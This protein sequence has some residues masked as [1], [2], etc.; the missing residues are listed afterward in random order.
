[1][2]TAPRTR[3]LREEQIIIAVDR[4][5][6]HVARHWVWLL[7][8]IG[9]L[10]AGLPVL[11]PVLESSGHHRVAGVIYRSFS[12]IC[13]QTPDHTFHLFGYRLAYCERCMSI[14]G[15]LLLL[16]LIYGASKRSLRPAT[17][18][19]AGVLSL[20]IALD[21]LTQLV[22]LRQS[23]WEIRVITGTLFSIAIAW[24]VMPRLDAGFRDVTRTVEAQFA[25]L[26]VEGR[27]KPLT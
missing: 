9:A 2:Q 3:S 27:A 17:L 26:V 25:R 14:Y 22:H 10:F 16:G 6:Y 23:T 20:P 13:S 5:I 12:L 18:I 24:L 19:E 15:G 8:I 7:N 4:A 11:A 21:G 1:M